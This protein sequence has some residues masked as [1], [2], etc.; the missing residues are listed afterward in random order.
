MADVYS[1]VTDRI[2]K[3]LEEGTVPWQK[4]WIGSGRAINYVSRKPYK[5]INTLLLDQP[6]EYLTFKQCAAL[7]GKI[8]KGEKAQ[9]IVFFTF[10]EHKEKDANGDD[11]ITTFPVLKYY[12][13]FHIT[14][15]E[16]IESKLEPPSPEADPLAEGET[17]IDGYISRS[18]VGFEAVKGSDRAFYRPSEDRVVVPHISQYQLVE[19]YYSTT[20]HE[21][22]HSTG[23]SSRLKRFGEKNDGVAAFGDEVY[24]KEELIAEIGSS[25]LMSI[26]G[27]ERPETF[28]NSASYLQSWLDVLKGDKR[29][30]VTAANAAQKA[31]D[32]IL[33]KSPAEA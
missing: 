20:F 29:L 10:S 14:Q 6:G 16:G 18:G 22:T 24:S 9:M 32:L 8:K 4:P 28:Q 33:G 5:G 13:V 23:H 21:L 26:A 1:I 25:M 31:V 27:I 7:G 12:S 30:I 11:K 15:C 19:E 2:I 3:A 17:I